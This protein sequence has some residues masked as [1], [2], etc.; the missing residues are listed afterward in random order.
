MYEPHKTLYNRIVR[1]SR[2]GMF[3]RIFAGLAVQDDPPD[4]ITIGSTPLKVDRTVHPKL[5]KAQA[6][7]A[8]KGYNR[9]AF[10]EAPTVS[11]ITPCLPP[12][13]KRRTPVSYCRTLHTRRHRIENMLAK[14]MDRRR[15]AIRYDRSAD[16]FVGT[17]RIATARVFW[18]G[19]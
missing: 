7:V 10:R 16:R 3:D 15:L 4:Q 9:D 14:L 18:I 11:G 8:D 19:K 13:A 2:I 5:P 6:L 12:R 1:R 17:I